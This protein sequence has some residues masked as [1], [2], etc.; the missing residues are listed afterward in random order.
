MLLSSL[1]FALKDV[2]FKKLLLL[3]L[4]VVILRVSLEKGNVNCKIKFLS[5]YVILSL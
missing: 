5:T 4:V 1:V 3:Y 2:L